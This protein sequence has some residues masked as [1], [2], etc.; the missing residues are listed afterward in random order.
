MNNLQ[1]T[2]K[3]IGFERE[4]LDGNLVLCI[5]NIGVGNDTF[6]IVRISDC[7]TEDIPND[8]TKKFIVDIEIVDKNNGDSLDGFQNIINV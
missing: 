8:E 6:A 7:D 5:D 3:K 1:E 4:A 2:L